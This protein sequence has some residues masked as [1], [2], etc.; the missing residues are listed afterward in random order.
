MHPTLYIQSF[1]ILDSRALQSYE[2]NYTKTELECLATVNAL[3]K[4]FYYLH[5]QKITIHTEH[6]ALV[7]LKNVKNLN[8]LE[9]Q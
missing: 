1:I 8:D 9:G 3:D 2:R 5:R 4:F 6:A 7:R